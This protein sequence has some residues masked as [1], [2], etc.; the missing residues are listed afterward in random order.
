MKSEKEFIELN[1]AGGVYWTSGGDEQPYGKIYLSDSKG[2]IPN[3]FWGKYSNIHDLRHFNKQT[4]DNFNK[5][6]LR[7]ALA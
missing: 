3:D 4:E 1:N 7:T 6:L 5:W 2:A